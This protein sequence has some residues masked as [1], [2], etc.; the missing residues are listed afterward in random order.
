M[1][2]EESRKFVKNLFNVP[3]QGFITSYMDSDLKII[4]GVAIV[5]QS[6][7]RVLICAFIHNK[8][9]GYCLTFKSGKLE[10]L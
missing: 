1:L 7:L 8:L 4:N 6:D 2:I 10:T 5:K 9:H 3:T